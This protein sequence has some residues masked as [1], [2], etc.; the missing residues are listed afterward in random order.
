MPTWL[1][2][3]SRYV[4]SRISCVHSGSRAIRGQG[5]PGLRR[6]P[7][8]ATIS[9]QYLYLSID[10][11]EYRVYV[12]EAGSGIPVLLQHTAVADGRQ[13][14]HLLEDPELTSRFRFI[15]PDLPYHGKSLPPSGLDWWN[16]DYRL[17]KAFL[18]AFVDAVLDGFDIPRAVYLGCSIGGHLAADLALALPHRFAAVIAVQ[19]AL[20][21]EYF[22][23]T[24]FV[25]HP[26]IQSPMGPLIFT[27]MAP[28]SPLASKHET[29]WLYQQGVPFVADGDNHYMVF[30]HDLTA[31]AH[32]IDTSK[33]A[34]YVMS[35]DYDRSI[36]RARSQ[37]LADAIPGS[38]FVAMDGLGHMAVSENPELFR[39]YLGPVLDEIARSWR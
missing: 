32:R 2:I 25:D 7:R 14:R 4:G 35:G 9:G 34:V 6:D 38:K 21:S 19:G 18:I 5:P 33:V 36:T 20:K 37:A 22:G 31:D 24:S 10:G 30:D 16:R 8:R 3:W 1:P 26:R 27:S 11:Y 28:T 13:Y 29:A 23:P 39:R 12:E 15:V 17:T